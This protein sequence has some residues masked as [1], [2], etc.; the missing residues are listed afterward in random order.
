MN[1]SRIAVSSAAA[2]VLVAGGFGV[3]SAKDQVSGGVTITGGTMVNTTTIGLDADGGSGMADASG[4]S[5]NVA[6]TNG[7]G[8]ASSGNGGSAVSDANGGVVV[9]GQIESGN[10]LGTWI[11]VG[12]TNWDGGWDGGGGD[13]HADPGGGAIAPCPAACP[14]DAASLDLWPLRH[15]IAQQYCAMRTGGDRK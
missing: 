9:T 15:T 8:T 11:E 7:V 2:L 6:M 14:C 13:H 10:N 12:N 3:A 1:V 4:G 5:N